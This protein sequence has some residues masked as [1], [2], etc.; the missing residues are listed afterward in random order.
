MKALPGFPTYASGNTDFTDS[1]R[2]RVRE[3]EQ[4]IVLDVEADELPSGMLCL[5]QDTVAEM[6]GVLGWQLFDGELQ[7][8]YANLLTE[9][10]E[11]QVRLDSYAHFDAA[12]DTLRPKPGRKK[13]SA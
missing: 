1:T 5:H 8:K 2:T 10:A 12:L 13:V 11:A 7:L 3:G 9:L 6:V 4:V